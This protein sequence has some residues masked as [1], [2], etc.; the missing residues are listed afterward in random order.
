[1]IAAVYIALREIYLPTL[2]EVLGQDFQDARKD[3]FFHPP[4]KAPV[5]GLG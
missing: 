1:L 2:F 5:A 4:L 3:A